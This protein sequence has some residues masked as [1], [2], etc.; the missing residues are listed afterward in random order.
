[1]KLQNYWPSGLS[2]LVVKA[3]YHADSKV[4]SAAWSR[5]QDEC[6]FDNTS[7][8][9]VRTASSA[10]RRLGCA[11]G[12]LE[13][14]LVGLRRYIWSAVHMRL[15]AAI[16]LLR[17]FQKGDVKFMMIK[18]SVL[19]ARDPQLAADRFMSD[20][21]VLVDHASWEKAVDIALASGWSTQRGV[22]RD[23]AI[24]RIRQLH[25]SFGLERGRNGSVDLHNFSLQLNQ[26]LGA[27]A[28]LWQRA[29][30]GKLAGMTVR[31]THPCDQLAIVLG[32]CFLYAPLQTHDWIYDVR[33]TIATEG[34][35]WNLCGDVILEREL[36][37]PAAAG[38]TYL[39]EELGWPIPKKSLQ[40]IVGRVRE[41]FVSEFAALHRSYKPKNP[42]QLQA[43]YRAQCIRSRR[44]VRTV[45]KQ[46][47]SSGDKIVETPF[48]GLK[49]GEKV[50]LALPSGVDPGQRV[51]FRLVLEG[52][53]FPS[54]SSAWVFLRCFDSMPLEFGR[55]RIHSKQKR[56][57]L[58]GTIDGALAVARGID[59]VWLQLEKKAP[60]GSSLRGD[61]RAK[62]ANDPWMNL[63][64]ITSLF[65]APRFASGKYER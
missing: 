31:L 22:T 6:D 24:Y 34:F 39:S 46:T 33:A 21:D 53:G 1:M 55:L 14:R 51:N 30:V 52:E 7:W 5:W 44:R 2:D 56:Q 64:R 3:A 65:A 36:A 15:G 16:P 17:N 19:L 62:V 49:A 45:P 35:D 26:Q 28:D 13:P 27:D 50:Y 61:F 10:Y 37:V 48:A 4:A 60:P 40:R 43:I 20:V 18:G 12:A 59:Q 57:V 11:Q 9:D 25:H 29:V 58:T 42:A 32:H 38:L 63:R 41:P 23:T 8:G 54:R 47:Q